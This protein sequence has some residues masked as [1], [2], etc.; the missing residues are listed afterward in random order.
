MFIPRIYHRHSLLGC[1]HCQAAIFSEKLWSII[2]TIVCVGGA[3]HGGL[4]RSSDD[5]HARGNLHATLHSTPGAV[6]STRAG[7][8]SKLADLH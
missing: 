2:I 6:R 3:T 5:I 4:R 7:Q 1:H 8:R